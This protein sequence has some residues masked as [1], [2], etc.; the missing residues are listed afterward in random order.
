METNAIRVLYYP[1]H[2][3]Y[4]GFSYDVNNLE[5]DEVSIE[6]LQQRVKQIIEFRVN[7]LQELGR[8]DEAEK[9]ASRQ[10]IFVENLN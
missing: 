3:S 5:V 1:A 7:I 4:A 2:N 8:K 9:L 6:A 10:L